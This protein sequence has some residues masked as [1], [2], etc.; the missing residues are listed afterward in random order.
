M[1]KVYIKYFGELVDKISGTDG[2]GDCAENYELGEEYICKNEKQ[3][4][5]K[6]NELIK[7][8]VNKDF[9][10]DEDTTLETNK[11]IELVQNN[12]REIIRLFFGKEENWN[13]YY[14]LVL[15]KLDKMA[16]YGIEFE[17]ISIINELIR[18]VNEEFQKQKQEFI[19]TQKDNMIAELSLLQEIMRYLDNEKTKNNI[20]IGDWRIVNN[21]IGYFVDEVVAIYYNSDLGNSYEDIELIIKEFIREFKEVEEE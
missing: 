9:V 1:Y 7:E 12:G 19:E 14:E 6:V 18:L 20:S 13:C 16:I 21:D 5:K 8:G 4:E 2:N 17:R 10:I 3:L 11:I 15:E